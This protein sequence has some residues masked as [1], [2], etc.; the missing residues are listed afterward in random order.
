MNHLE[1]LLHGMGGA[2]MWAAINPWAWAKRAIKAELKA[3]VK[4]YGDEL[5]AQTIEAVKSQKT[6]EE[7]NAFYD[8]AEADIIAR[9]DAF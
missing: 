7:I 4:Q 5:R 9:I 1:G 6:E 8:K 3:V 2:I